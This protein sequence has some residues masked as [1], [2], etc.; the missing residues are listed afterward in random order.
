MIRFEGDGE[1]PYYYCLKMRD[2]TLFITDFA[3][4]Y[5][6]FGFN[7]LFIIM[8]LKVV[9]IKILYSFLTDV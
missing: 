4:G 5:A 9:L 3:G 8:L 2:V 1:D 6:D 7:V